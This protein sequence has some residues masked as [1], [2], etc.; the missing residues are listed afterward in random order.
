MNQQNRRKH[1]KLYLKQGIIS[2][3][4]LVLTI[5]LCIASSLTQ[6]LFPPVINKIEVLS[7][8]SYTRSH[9]IVRISCK[10]LYYTGYDNHSKNKVTGHYY[11]TMQDNYCLFLLLDKSDTAPKEKLAHYTGTFRIIKDETLFNQLTKSLSKDMVWSAQSLQDISIP[12]IPS[13]PDYHTLP[14][15]ILA[16][17]LFLCFLI[18]SYGTIRNF[19][20]YNKYF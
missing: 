12:A 20:Y 19:Y 3:V 4:L 1:A 14:V 8:P 6:T 2:L 17:G 15:I 9:P 13:E 5:Y 18:F 11:Y 16:I 10:N 7:S